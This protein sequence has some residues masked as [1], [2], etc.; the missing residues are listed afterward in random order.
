MCPQTTFCGYYDNLW[1]IIG[2]L[3]IASAILIHY[4][5]WV[6]CYL[7]Q[8]QVNYLSSH[9]NYISILISF[10]C[11]LQ[12]RYTQLCPLMN[13]YICVYLSHSHDCFPLYL[14][15]INIYSFVVC[16][17]IYFYLFFA[18]ISSLDTERVLPGKEFF[19]HTLF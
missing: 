12:I 3:C 13:V 17:G 5:Q 11:M 14:Y 6:A 4:N 10:T 1:L 19:Q 9:W 16:C 2:S 18:F 7:P 8:W 15:Y